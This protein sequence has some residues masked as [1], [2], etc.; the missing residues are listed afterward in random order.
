M[1]QITQLSNKH[2]DTVL[3]LNEFAFQY[4]IPEH[5]RMQVKQKF[6]NH[7]ILGTM[8]GDTIAAKVH[9][10]PFHCYVNKKPFK[11]GGIA[12]E[13]GRAS[14]RERVSF[15]EGGESVKGRCGRYDSS[16]TRSMT[17]AAV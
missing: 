11:M 9:V 6:D 13:I 5:R 17:M 10:I 2:Y 3:A 12:S 4:E 15:S 8:D 16:A 14:C 7:T 1:K